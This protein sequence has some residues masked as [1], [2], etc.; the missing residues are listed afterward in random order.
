M[1]NQL[2]SI[3]EKMLLNEAEKSEL[4][5][6]TNDEVGSLKA[7]QELFSSKPKPVEGPDK[8]KVKQGPAYEQTAGKAEAPKAE[9]SSIKNAAPAKAAEPEEAKEVKDTE[10][11][12]NKEEKEDEK[13][14]KKEE[15]KD[16][17]N[18]GITLSAFETL[19]KKTLTEELGEETETYEEETNTEETENES[20]EEESAEEGD[21]NE[22]GDL[23]SDLRDLQDRLAEILAKLEDVAEEGELETDPESEEYTEQDFDDEFSDEKP[24]KE[25]VEKP[26]PLA[27]AKGKS[28]QSKQNKIGSIKPKGGKAHTGKVKEEPE[29]KA[30]GDKKAHL[31]KGKP[32]VSSSVKKGDF[33]K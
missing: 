4:Q 33:I 26:A 21:L 18:E 30:L 27:D 20:S 15:K 9:S 25:A 8:A 1:K 13:E 29:P 32:E 5:N 22:D 12:P 16:Q 14:E 31:Q 2:A 19:F 28:L 10:V 6:P 17:K 7:K 3:Y 11:D 23:L 24:V